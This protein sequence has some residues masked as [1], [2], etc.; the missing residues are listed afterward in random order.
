MSSIA[1]S[2][3]PLQIVGYRKADEPFAASSCSHSNLTI[4]LKC[5]HFSICLSPTKTP[6]F[7][8][9]GARYPRQGGSLCPHIA[10]PLEGGGRVD[11]R[12]P[13]SGNLVC[14]L[15]VSYLWWVNNVPL[16]LILTWSMRTCK[17]RNYSLTASINAQQANLGWIT[18]SFLWHILQDQ[19]GVIED[20]VRLNDQRKAVFQT[21][22][23]RA[24]MC[25]SV[26]RTWWW[27]VYMYF[28]FC[29]AW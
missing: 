23:C 22:H 24:A 3:P 28:F 7:P 15:W 11:K 9:T 29:V 5:L 14:H 6:K 8:D 12:P 1:H 2:F 13:W 17:R 18:S 27:L 20:F 26:T 21:L 10:P 25:S 16:Y 19:Y 4:R